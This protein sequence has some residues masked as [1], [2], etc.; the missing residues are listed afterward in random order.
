M[1][2]G[3]VRELTQ[4]RFVP[5]LKRNLISIGILDQT[6]CVIKAEKGILR[7]IKGSMVIMKGIKQNGHVC[8]GWTYYCWRG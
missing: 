1:F 5:E 3:V 4:V 7:V 6:G 8:V 2:N